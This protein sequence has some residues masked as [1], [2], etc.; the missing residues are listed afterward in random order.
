MSQR[1]LECTGGEKCVTGFYKESKK[2]VDLLKPYLHH[3]KTDYDK[4]WQ[5]ASL[6]RTKYFS[7]TAEITHPGYC[8]ISTACSKVRFRETSDYGYKLYECTGKTFYGKCIL[9]K[10]IGEDDL[11]MQNI[12]PF[13]FTLIN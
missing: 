7:W 9:Y 2:G 12:I 6:A 5:L 4:C 10:L 1:I 13:Y 11:D 8:K 3:E